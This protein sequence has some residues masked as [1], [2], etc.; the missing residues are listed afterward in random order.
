MKLEQCNRLRDN[1]LTGGR[2]CAPAS[3]CCVEHPWLHLS[4]AISIDS[5]NS[6]IFAVGDEPYCLWESDVGERTRDFLHGLDA[7]FFS[8]VLQAHMAAV[9]E[10]RASVAIRLALHHGTETL[11]SLLGAFVQAADCPYAWIAQCRTEDLRKVVS[12]IGAG[13][14]SLITKW[15]K[16]FLGWGDVAAAVLST[17]QPGTEKHKRNV[18]G[19]GKAWHALAGE[20]QDEVVNHEYNAIKHGFRTRSG[21][22][23]LAFGRQEA[24]GVPAPE[25]AMKVLGGSQFGAMFYKVEKFKGKGGRHLRSRKTSVNWSSE[26]DI[27]LVQLIQLSINNVISALK[28]AN[29]VPAN[30]CQFQTLGDD[31]DF[32]RAWSYSTGVTNMNFDFALDENELPEVT[33]ADILKKLRERK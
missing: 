33:K 20:L 14:E 30:E 28:V 26:R 4:W 7:E 3:P 16:P 8:Y 15:E 1:F 6:T 12:R 25:S 9:D 32:M 11:F 13:D 17:C 27:L 5:M 22:F 21:G 24:E 19:F 10:K 2:L 23:K 18:T 29:G 31:E